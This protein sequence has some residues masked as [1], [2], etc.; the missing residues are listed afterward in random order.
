MP[1]WMTSST[2]RLLPGTSL[3]VPGAIFRLSTI[4]KCENLRRTSNHCATLLVK[5]LNMTYIAGIAICTCSKLSRD[6]E[7][8]S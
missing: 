8:S 3:S 1:R 5:T 7:S 6:V 4:V 2:L